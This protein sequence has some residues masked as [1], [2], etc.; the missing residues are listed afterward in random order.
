MAIVTMTSP[1]N[2]GSS[3]GGKDNTTIWILGIAAA[4]AAYLG[5]QYFQNKKKKELAQKASN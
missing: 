1:V 3:E 5:W 4:A 2:A